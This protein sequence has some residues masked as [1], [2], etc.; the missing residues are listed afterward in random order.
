MATHLQYRSCSAAVAGS[1]RCFLW[2]MYSAHRAF[3]VVDV[4]LIVS[5]L[6]AS[7]FPSEHWLATR[8]SDDS[9]SHFTVINYF[10]IS[11]SLLLLL[12]LNLI[13]VTSYFSISISL[14]FNYFSIWDSLSLRLLANYFSIWH[15]LSLRLLASTSPS[16]SQ[17]TLTTF[18]LTGITTPSQSN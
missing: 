7:Q 8:S 9:R 1:C 15:S 17:S 3:G 14:H 6:S 13:S 4:L 10:S 5:R 12:H 2:N 16:Q 18:L 11:I